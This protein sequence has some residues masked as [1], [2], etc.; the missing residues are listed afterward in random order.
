MRIALLL[1]DPQFDFCN[2]QGALYVPGAE[3]D[4]TRIAQLIN[5]HGDK[6]DQL[7]ITLDTHQV[8]DISHPGFWTDSEG[9]LPA[10][11][12][13]ITA[14]DVDN[15][16][17]IPRFNPAY[18][19]NYL[20]ELD[21]QGQYQHVIWPEHCLVGTKGAALD[22]AIASAALRWVHNRG[23]NYKAIMKGLHPFTEHFGAFRAQI[24]VKGAPETDLNTPLIASLMSFDKI[25][26]AG[27]ARSHCIASSLSQLMQYAPE[28]VAKL[29]V[30]TDCM[31]DVAGLGHLADPILQKALAD[32]V[33]FAKSDALFQ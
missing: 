28:L 30:L 31:S 16:Q 18:V 13:L 1:I 11:F 22:E 10:P 26:L 19:R 33:Q 9:I 27:E 7:I 8:L 5:N 23:Q 4:V 20:H 17:W 32:G 21:N 29:I 3:E 15:Q 6:I 12:T 14:A 24:P 25:L 2:P